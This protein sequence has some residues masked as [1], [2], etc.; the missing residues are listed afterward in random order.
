MIVRLEDPEVRKDQ[1]EAMFSEHDK[2]L[3]QVNSCCDCPHKIIPV[4]TV[5]RGERGSQALFPNCEAVKLMPSQREFLNKWTPVGQSFSSE[6]SH[7]Y[8]NV[9]N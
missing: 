5:H 2:T 4:N 1:I 8:G 3:V 7:I 9:G 6:W